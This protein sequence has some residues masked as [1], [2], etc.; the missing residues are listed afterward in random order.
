MARGR[1]RESFLG[2]ALGTQGPQDHSLFAPRKPVQ[3]LA[4]REKLGGVQRAGWEG[5]GRLSRMRGWCPWTPGSLAVGS[6]ARSKGFGMGHMA[7]SRCSVAMELAAKVPCDPNTSYC[8]STRSQL[9][10]QR[11]CPPAFALDLLGRGF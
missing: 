8:P 3:A 2:V 4:E 6:V 1:L 7:H 9:F 10:Q 11:L 5:G